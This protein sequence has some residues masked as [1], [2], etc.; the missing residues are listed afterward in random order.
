MVE[1]G[2]FNKLQVTRIS[3]A[4][5]HLAI[6]A[7]DILLPLK[8]VPA[9]L[10]P[11]DTVNVFVY[12]NSDGRLIPSTIGPKVEVGQFAI[13]KVA[14]VGRF[15]AFLDWGLDKELLVPFSEQPVPM[16]KG[17]SYVVGVYVDNSGRLAASAKI[18]KFLDKE[19]V[20]LKTG[21]EVDLMI[22]EFTNL[23]D[24]GHYQWSVRRLAVRKRAVRQTRTGGKV[25][26]VCQ[27]DP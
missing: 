13:L 12:R 25:K 14:D 10:S 22:Y 11:G 6:E 23:E 17:E 20:T 24:Q 2:R 7:G 16:K 1:I 26:G 4:G 5:A 18:A 27:K 9:G 21:D 15:G 3:S 19:G 8:Q